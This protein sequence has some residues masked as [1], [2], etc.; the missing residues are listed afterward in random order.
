MVG[1]RLFGDASRLGKTL[2]A[3]LGLALALE[4]SFAILSAAGHP[5]KTDYMI[6][7]YE[8]A[9]FLPLLWVTLLVEGPLLEELF[10]RGFMFQGIQRSRLGDRGDILLL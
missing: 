10:F 1:A 4:G 9:G 5:S 3:W 6:Q 2:L 8:T 7:V